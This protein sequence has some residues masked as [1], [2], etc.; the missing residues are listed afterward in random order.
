MC[1]PIHFVSKAVC[2]PQGFFETSSLIVH[3]WLK[4]LK[5]FLLYSRVLKYFS[6]WHHHKNISVRLSYLNLNLCLVTS[7]L[8]RFEYTDEWSKQTGEKMGTKISRT[9]A[10]ILLCWRASTINFMFMKS[11]MI[12]LGGESSSS[13]RLPDHE[14]N[15]FVFNQRRQGQTE[16]SMPWTAFSKRCTRFFTAS[17]LAWNTLDS[18]LLESVSNSC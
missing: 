1:I 14:R 13:S 17:T 8:L 5:R 18:S 16:P 6:W 10:L 4:L 12:S 9:C 15:E 11:S 7:P 2:L 3:L